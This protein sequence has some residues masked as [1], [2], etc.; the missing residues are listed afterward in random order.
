MRHNGYQ[1]A[2]NLI[3]EYERCVREA[4]PSWFL[5]EEVPDAPLPNVP[6]YMV[7]DQVLLDVEVGGHTS[8]RRRFSFGSRLAA[9]SAGTVR[10]PRFA[11]DTLAL[12]RPDPAQAVL[13]SGGY[14]AVDG[15]VASKSNTHRNRHKRR[16]GQLGRADA[17][18]FRQ[19]VKLQGLPEDFDLP[20]FLVEEKVRAIG[21]GVPL[22]MG[23]A[24]ARAVRATL[25]LP[26]AAP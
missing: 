8:R 9:V 1:V 7:Q 21:N 11:V 4:A 25:G 13:A 19:A 2:E 23:R 12:H 6:G 17:K 20:G 26:N 14:S 3:P 18:Y 22:A 5:V 10:L 16:A 24:V 15:G